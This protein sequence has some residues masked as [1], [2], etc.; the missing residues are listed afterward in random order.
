MQQVKNKKI[1]FSCDA[2]EGSGE[3]TS[4]RTEVPLYECDN[5]F[6]QMTVKIV[7]NVRLPGEPPE[8]CINNYTILD[9]MSTFFLWRIKVW[10]F[11]PLPQTTGK[12][13]DCVRILPKIWGISAWNSS[14]LFLQ[15][16]TCLLL[17]QTMQ[18][19]KYI[20][21]FSAKSELRT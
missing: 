7:W 15:R 2:T 16:Y 19:G 14:K 12:G 20:A 17:R 8:K 4:R 6:F 5:F 21:N 1:G 13:P 3:R 18:G 9:L 10:N 11:W